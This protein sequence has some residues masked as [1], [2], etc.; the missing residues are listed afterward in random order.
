[1][2]EIAKQLPSAF[3]SA[4]PHE[5]RRV[6]G[7]LA[8]SEQRV[9]ALHCASRDARCVIAKPHP[10]HAGL[11]FDAARRI[12]SDRFAAGRSC[13]VDAIAREIGPPFDAVRDHENGAAANA[14]EISG[15]AAQIPR[16]QQPIGF[17]LHVDHFVNQRGAALFGQ[18]CGQ[19]VAALTASTPSEQDDID[20]VVLQIRNLFDGLDASGSRKTSG[21]RVIRVRADV[22]PEA[23][24]RERDCAA[25]RDRQGRSPGGGHRRSGT[26][27]DGNAHHQEAAPERG[28]RSA[29]SSARSL[30][31]MEFPSGSA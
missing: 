5:T 18:P 8:H 29:T 10:R 12:A 25:I 13:R 14:E 26:D 31:T 9:H 27:D 22:A 4:F 23:C 21:V 24:H 6:L 28:I 16:H 3:L 17:P 1:M 2:T 19:S 7:D 15:A 20:A 11:P 30:T